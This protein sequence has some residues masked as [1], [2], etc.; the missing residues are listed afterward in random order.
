MGDIQTVH[1]TE[2]GIPPLALAYV[3]FGSFWGCLAVTV[4]DLLHD[5]G[6]NAGQ[7]GFY[8]TL[9]SITGIVTMAWI[10]PRL[11][12]LPRQWTIPA[13][14][15]IEGTGAILLAILPA[16]GLAFAFITIGV[17]TGLVD[18]LVNAV[19]YERERASGRAVLQWVHMTYSV[20]GGAGAL[21]AGILLTTGASWRTALI[22]T[23]T[24]QLMAGGINVFSSTLRGVPERERSEE[25][26]SLT[27]FVRWP[28]LLVPALIVASAFFVEGSMDVWSGVYLQ[29]SLGASA[30]AAAVGFSAFAFATA[31]GRALA[32]RILFGLGYRRT[33]I[34]S[35]IGAVLAG[36]AAVLAPT[37]AVAGIAYLLLGFCIAAAAPAAFGS[38]EGGDPKTAGLAIA[39][40]TTAGYS[41]FIVGPPL[42]GWLADATGSFR[43]TMLLI[44]LSTL[45]VLI[46]GLLI[47]HAPAK[48][49]PVSESARGEGA[50]A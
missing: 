23:G 12:H 33:V 47:R 4:G 15:A 27:A 42:L 46:G 25:K 50:H 10:A 9:T 20:G 22:V 24:A 32:A 45:G 1:Y 2:R 14:I 41:G 21:M 35:G 7:L 37:I 8:L 6:L 28:Y 43:I 18:V 40:V 3:A 29:Q 19:G 31:A 30:M 26:V 44:T 11:E 49:P 34:A 5:R 36:L 38:I 48:L 13:A 17:G 39:A 16:R